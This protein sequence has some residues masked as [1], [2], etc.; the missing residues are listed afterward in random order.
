MPPASFFQIDLKADWS[1]S[2]IYFSEAH[3][4]SHMREKNNSPIVIILFKK[5]T[6]RILDV[7]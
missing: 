5:N 4:F 7:Y 6:R 3:V 2:D 1:N